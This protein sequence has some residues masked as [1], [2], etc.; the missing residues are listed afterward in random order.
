[1]SIRLLVSIVVFF[2]YSTSVRADHD[3]LWNKM[4]NI[5]I[6]EYKINGIYKPCALVDLNEKYVIY[7][8]DFDKY[9]YLLLPTDK[10]SGTE[11]VKLQQDAVPNYLYLAWQSRSFL[12]ERFNKPIK[13]QLLSLTINPK[14]NREQNQ[15]H[16]HISCLSTEARKI[17]SD[18]AVDQLDGQWSSKQVSIAP[19]SYFYRKIN[20]DEF[21]K[22]NLFKSIKAKVEQENGNMDYT[23]VALV[24]ID[25][26]NFLLLVGIGTKENG[27]SA[28]LIQEHGCKAAEQ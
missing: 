12:T 9:Q 8:T 10:I 6:P 19:Y 28:E 21:K 13:E 16:I 20:L 17:I 7:K 4:N 26:N 22:E 27:F 25:P 14:N 3:F 24:N 23:G 5:C 11:D 15:L 1:M 2:I 18:I